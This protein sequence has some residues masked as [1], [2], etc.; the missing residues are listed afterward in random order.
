MSKLVSS[1][2][3]NRIE[4][5]YPITAST[6]VWGNPWYIVASVAFSASNQPEAIPLV[7]QHALQSTKSH[8]ERLLLARKTRDAIFKAGLNSG[9]ARGINSL[10]ALDGVMPEELKDRE[11]S[12]NRATSSQEHEAEGKKFFEELYGDTAGSVQKLLDDIYPDMGWFST[13][14]GYGLV[15]GHN[16]ILTPLETSYTLVST[17]IA[18]DTPRQIN[19][20]LN[21]AR[22][23]GAT[24]DE[25]KAV[26]EIAMEVASLSGVR[27][28]EGVPEVQIESE[29]SK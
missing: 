6:K 23:L 25:V 2:F 17:L 5:I 4:S 11:L 7:F 10:I 13:T 3:L 29:S 14:I 20:H 18:G 26:R 9:Y 24:L 27:W 12:R 8:D 21:G 19:W 15:Y 16:Q 1:A 28:K 22:R